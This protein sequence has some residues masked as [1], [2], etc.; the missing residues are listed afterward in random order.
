MP[1]VRIDLSDRRDPARRRAVSDGVHRAFVDTIG[2]PEG[3]R[4]HV[5]T[6]H[7]D[8]ELIADPAY[9]GIDREDMISI[10]ITMVRGRSKELKQR[11]YRAIATNLAEI[12]GV[13][14]EDVSIVVVENGPE[15][16]SYGNGVAQLL[17]MPPVAGTGPSAE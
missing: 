7:P 9:L 3:D 4:F 8:E 12:D 17:S 11:L 15:D 14:A 1:T 6:T 5:I 10:Q 2:I 16:Y 13:R